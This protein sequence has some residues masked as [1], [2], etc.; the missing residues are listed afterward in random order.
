[1]GNCGQI[2]KQ[3]HQEG[4]E[5]I[6]AKYETKQTE[7]GFLKANEEEL[8]NDNT[9]DTFYAAKA[10]KV[11][12]NSPE[13]LFQEEI[14]EVDE[15]HTN[16]RKVSNNEDLLQELENDYHDLSKQ[17]FNI[18][19]EMR[20]NPGMFDRSVKNPDLRQVLIS[21]DSIEYRPDPI[22]WSEKTY[23]TCTNYLENF[24][25]KNQQSDEEI[26]QFFNKNVKNITGEE[27][28]TFVFISEVWKIENTETAL[29]E[30]LNKNQNQFQTILSNQFDFGAVCAFR[31]NQQMDKIILGLAV[32]EQYN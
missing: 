6:A 4:N 30:L 1:M 7:K 32:K 18:L 28:K 17:I 22:L 24:N 13:N 20:I 14:K 2:C 26:F 21:N 31:V 10:G 25:E 8:G 9:R 23:S 27:Y 29:I 3:N 15:V 16:S 5:I 12:K 11:Q 19:N